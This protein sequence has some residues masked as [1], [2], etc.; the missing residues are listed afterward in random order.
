MS[1]ASLPLDILLVILWDLSI[2]DVVRIGMVSPQQ[3]PFRFNLN[4]GTHSQ[5]SFLDN[6]DF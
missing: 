5:T 6:A 3:L 4:P 1:F 2:A